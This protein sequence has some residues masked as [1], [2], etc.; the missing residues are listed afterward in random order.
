MF[1]IKQE[2][3]DIIEA[4]NISNA[5]RLLITRHREKYHVIADYAGE[6]S[7]IL[8]KCDTSDFAQK[9]IINLLMR[10][11]DGENCIVESDILEEIERQ[12]QIGESKEPIIGLPLPFDFKRGIVEDPDSIYNLMLKY[13]RQELDAGLSL[14][15]ILN[16]I[17]GLN[18]ND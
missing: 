17:K 11:R 15:Q 7:I 10:T 13:I 8:H 6:Q 1:L 14:E 3:S 5:S 16:N 2:D 12:Q 18:K 4:I 9:Y